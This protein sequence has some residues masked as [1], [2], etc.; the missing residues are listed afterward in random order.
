MRV[1]VDPPAISGDTVVFQWRQS[2]PN[3]FQHANTFFLRYENVDLRNFSPLLFYEIFLGLQLGVFAGYQTRVEVV[4][5]EPVPRT[6]IAFWQAYHRADRV[7]VTPV[8]EAGSYSP[9]CASPPARPR[10][11]TAG[12]FF[13][14]GKDSTLTI[15]LLSEIYGADEVVAIQ[16]V[17]PF[18][19]GQTEMERLAERQDALMLRPAREVLGV[20]T[21]RAWTDYLANLKMSGEGRRVRPHLELYTL[22]LLPVLLTWDVSICTPGLARGAYE[23]SR[24][25][26]GRFGFRYAQSRPE[27]LATQSTHYRRVIGADLAVTNLHLLFTAPM[28]M[29]LLIERYPHALAQIVMCVQARGLDRWCFRCAKCTDYAFL[30]LLCRTVDPRFDYDRLFTGS[31]HIK[32][33][34]A[35]TESGDASP[36]SGNAPRRP[37]FALDEV[38]PTLCHTI[39]SADPALIAD[40]LSAQ[41]YANLMT[42]KTLYDNR[43]FPYVELLSTQTVDLL[44]N[45]LARAVGRIAAEHFQVVDAL[46]G[47]YYAGP[48]VELYDFGV[49]MPARTGQ[50]DHIRG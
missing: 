27:M 22:G 49:R 23:I 21:Q 38:N 8:A 28:S 19:P 5:P 11:R 47:P 17:H 20:A 2:E 1:E 36:V 43:L 10:R 32:K 6:T 3:P 12:V 15:C 30:S 24:F 26:D 14:G 31:R 41:G 18:R 39:A 16:Y 45:E 46:P 29:R 7:T 4:L 40:R 13:G 9:W 50:L 48:G 35:C 34:M 44:D 42:L 37:V 25:A 33:L